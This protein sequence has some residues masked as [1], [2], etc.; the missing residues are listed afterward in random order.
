MVV[1]D[2]TLLLLLLRPDAG[3]PTDRTTNAPV[4][5]FKARLDY[6]VEQMQEAGEKIVIPTPALSEVLVRA[7]PAGPQI[8]EEISSQSVFRI[9]AFDVMEAVEV[10]EM[11][12]AAIGAGDKRGGVVATMAKIKYDRQIVAT[13]RVAG[14]HTIYTDDEGIR[15]FAERINIS[16][17]GL[18]ELPERPLPPQTEMDFNADAPQDS[19]APVDPPGDEAS[20]EEKAR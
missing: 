16:V 19:G 17:I 9:A 11:T 13:A 8:I 15:T 14:A 10:A 4:S 5:N 6:W 2:A 12:R 20:A 3:V 7:G 1:I 18:A